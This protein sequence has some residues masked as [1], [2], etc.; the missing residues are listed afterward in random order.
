V[1]EN[2]PFPCDL[3]VLNASNPM[4]ICYVETKNLDG[5]TNLK[6]KQANKEVLKMAQNDEDVLKNFD[7]AKIECEPPNEFLYKFEGK[8]TMPN[9]KVFSLDADQITLRGSTL[10]NT[11]WIYGIAIY[12]GHQTKVMMNSAKSVSK[13][14]NIEKATNTYIIMCL[15]IQLTISV[16]AAYL[17]AEIQYY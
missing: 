3:L 15:G 14:S 7:N 13:Q 12:T 10:Q 5:E 2:Q 11:E 16:I 9:G 8:M 4:G 17:G 6:N 1:V